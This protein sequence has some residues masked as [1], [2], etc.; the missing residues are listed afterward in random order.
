[1]ALV[2]P[3]LR[4]WVIFRVLVGEPRNW[5]IKKGLTRFVPFNM[6]EPLKHRPDQTRD[7][8]EKG[9]MGQFPVSG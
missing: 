1:L 4:F 5:L 3:L 6:L 2:S 9:A 8:L 7:D